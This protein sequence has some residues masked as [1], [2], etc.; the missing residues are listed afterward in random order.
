MNNPTED[1]KHSATCEFFYRNGQIVP[2]KNQKEYPQIPEDTKIHVTSDYFVEG[3]GSTHASLQVWF[4]PSNRTPAPD[5]HLTIPQGHADFTDFKISRKNIKTFVVETPTNNQFELK[6]L[7]IARPG[8]FL[9][10][11]YSLCLV[12]SN[13]H[14]V[15]IFDYQMIGRKQWQRKQ[16][17]LEG[18]TSRA[19]LGSRVSR[20]SLPPRIA[21]TE[22]SKDGGSDVFRKDGTEN[23][24]L[25]S[26]FPRRSR[27]EVAK[28]PSSHS[29]PSLG[30]RKRSRDEIPDL[31]SSPA[32]SSMGPRKRSRDDIPEHS[33]SPPQLSSSLGPRKRSRDEI[34]D[35]PDCVQKNKRCSLDEI[36]E[37]SD[38]TFIRHTK[39]NLGS[40]HKSHDTLPSFS[41]KSVS[42]DR[43]PISHMRQI[44]TEAAS[45]LVS[46]SNSVEMSCTSDVPSSPNIDN[47]EDTSID[48]S[49]TRKWFSNLSLESKS[50]LLS[51]TSSIS[52]IKLDFSTSHNGMNNVVT[53]LP[54]SQPFTFPSLD[55]KGEWTV[56]R[57]L[58]VPSSSPPLVP[59]PFY[60]PSFSNYS[61]V[62]N[63]TSTGFRSVL[64]FNG[65]GAPTAF[66]PVAESQS[67]NSSNTPPPS[68][69]SPSPLTSLLNTTQHTGISPF[70]GCA[71]S[72]PSSNSPQSVRVGSESFLREIKKELAGDTVY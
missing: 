38:K 59:P 21:V 11:K 25:S 45:A 43:S 12:F 27:D 67:L 16:K 46:I 3:F 13:G 28:I 23:L 52:H 60:V 69:P 54:M 31:N 53:K 17:T 35:F 6:H 48:E 29:S 7:K 37:S 51:P 58:P 41:I 44:S 9:F 50:P 14:M 57:S 62:K 65:S 26:S 2:L 70:F 56:G 72:V 24:N 49:N 33:S 10:T 30:S 40:R 63:E 1:G 34:P 32:L 66:R 68:S 18:A 64:N 22:E 61:G 71:S 55:R 39:G 42:P 19:K 15:S 5:R 20:H 47:S 4:S 8:G 36:P